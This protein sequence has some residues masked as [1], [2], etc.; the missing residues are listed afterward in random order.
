MRLQ[1]VE[2][3]A[4][5]SVTSSD[6][7]RTDVFTV[8]PG[9]NITVQQRPYFRSDFGGVGHMLFIWDYEPRTIIRATSAF[10]HSDGLDAA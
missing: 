3:N 10:R 2:V 8:E 4:P 6:C 7:S 5:F 9:E 1:N